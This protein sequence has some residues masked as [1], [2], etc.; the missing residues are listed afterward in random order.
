MMVRAEQP[1]SDKIPAGRA[2]SG[3]IDNW[4]DL[5]IDY[6]DDALD[7]ATKA[8]VDAHLTSCASCAARLGVQRTVCAVLNQTALEEP[9]SDLE[10]RVLGEIMFPS[11]AAATV[12]AAAAERSRRQDMWRKRFRPWI[13][14]TVALVALFAVAISIAVLRGGT[15]ADLAATTTAAASVAMNE[16]ARAADDTGAE[17]MPTT[18]APATT[19][20]VAATGAGQTY[21]YA[22]EETV[23]AGGTQP[24]GVGSGA[25][26][27]TA[28]PTTTMAT[29][30][31]QE[32]TTTS[33]ALMIQDKKQM[34]TELKTASA[35]VYFV[36]EATATKTSD[37]TTREEFASDLANQITMLT[38]LQP[39]GG[40]L[41]LG[42]ATFA[43][44][45]P[46]EDATALVELLESIGASL[47]L[48]VGLAWEPVGSGIDLSQHDYA[49]ALRAHAAQF[50]ELD[51]QKKPPSVSIY[52]FTTSTLVAYDDA[53]TPS[54]WLAP[55]EA[56]TH[57]LVVIYLGA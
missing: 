54:D 7:G 32:M 3:H 51:A 16:T 52:T 11:K 9:P 14:A 48:T 23:P 37:G 13:P 47:G 2:I 53:E 44:Y 56:G 28:A 41:A 15:A 40:D 4:E 35:P 22:T 42:A 1:N 46:R 19:V 6:L 20:T 38:G 55:D 5:V 18:A 12:R 45:V 8:A 34:I 24:P 31:A 49:S 26:T 33:K 39:V 27:T 25:P 50:P 43:A 30:G 17:A 57:V 29:F 21:P 36:F 10:D